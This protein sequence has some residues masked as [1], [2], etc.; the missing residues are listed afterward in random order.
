MRHAIFAAL[1]LLIVLDAHAAEIRLK[2]GSIVI[3]T[4]LSL[5]DGEDLVVDTEYMDNV[6][7]EW[8]AIADIQGTQIV[9]VE[10]FDG[11]RVLGT[12]TFDDYGMSIM[13]D[14]TMAVD[15]K[16]VFAISEVNETF[17]E[18]IDAYTDLGM[19]IV[20]GNNQVTQVSFGG[21]VG[22]DA[23]NFEL[24]LDVTSI[25]NEQTNAE[26]TRR[27]T[28][29]ASYLHKFD[30]RWQTITSYSFESDEQQG[31][32]G[33]SLLSLAG[34]RQLT[35]SRRQRLSIGAGAAINSEKFDGLSQE[36]SLEGLINLTYRLRS[37]VDFDL[38]YTYL[39]SLEG[40]SRY[41]TQFDATL[42]LDLIADFDFKVI[43]YDR[44]DSQPP[45]GN[46]NNDSGIT[47]ALSWDY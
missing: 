5:A 11:T 35:N 42:S 22:Y 37:R 18:A 39:P 7:I 41:R 14:D 16:E 45:A 1:A 36:E 13:G 43:A 12:V 25:T 9:D 29:A 31:L 19:N 2:D 10:L 3:G 6:T 33:R 44:F 32:D 34:G 20:R 17:W 28:L 47:L 46:S 26:D 27:D 8:D 38:S 15:P 40:G 24:S 21:G 30:N 23:Q 4:I